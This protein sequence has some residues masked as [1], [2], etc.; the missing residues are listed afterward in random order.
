MVEEVAIV[1]VD[2]AAQDPNVGL[3]F[4]VWRSDEVQLQEVRERGDKVP[5]EV[6]IAQWLKSWRGP[7]LLAL[8]APLGWP[9]PLGQALASHKAG[10]ELPGEPDALFRR[11]TDR[12]IKQAV[13]KTPLDVG[14]DR[15]ART[16][17]AA[18]EL[19]TKLRESLGA[20]IPLVWSCNSIDR[21]GAIEVYPAAALMAHGCRSSGYKKAADVAER[22][23][24]IEF[25]GKSIKMPTDVS[26]LESNADALDAVV[27]L[28]AAQDF[29]EGRAVPP[30][31]SAW[32]NGKAGSGQPQR[33]ERM[34]PERLQETTG[35]RMRKLALANSSTFLHRTP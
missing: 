24:I 8:D 1:G 21:F 18:L 26:H 35:T 23:E 15:I 30:R 19:L 9:A 3:A 6:T 4:G 7:A 33:R 27:C 14:A 13:G 11:A 25:L 2:C 16:A 31:I 20:P 5:A 17:H 22:R 28:L 34:K 32:R 12:V 10:E 29:L